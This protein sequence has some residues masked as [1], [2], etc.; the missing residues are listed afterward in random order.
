MSIDVL[1]WTLDLCRVNKHRIFMNPIQQAL[2]LFAFSLALQATA[3]QIPAE[4]ADDRSNALKVSLTNFFAYT[5]HMD[6]EKHLGGQK[7]RSIQFSGGISAAERGPSLHKESLIGGHGEL[8]F[9]AYLLPEAQKLKGLYVAPFAKYNY[10][11]FKNIEDLRRNGLITDTLRMDYTIRS[12]SSGITMGYQ[13]VF[14]KI[15]VLDTYIGGGVRIAQSTNTSGLTSDFDLLDNEAYTGVIPKM[16][17]KI[18][19]LF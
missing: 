15:V 5:F 6:Y 14:R 13:C 7:G 10:L 3:Q 9:R 16:G 19:V 1:P 8:Q 18:G 11:E 12:F 2:R 4:A 17:F